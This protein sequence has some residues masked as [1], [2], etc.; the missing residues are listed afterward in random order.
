LFRSC[1][2]ALEEMRGKMREVRKA[3]DDFIRQQKEER[4]RLERDIKRVRGRL[5]NK[6][7]SEFR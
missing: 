1:A 4:E 5:A 3:R 6:A 7:A 2:Q